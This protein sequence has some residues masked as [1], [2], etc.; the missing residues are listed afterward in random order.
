MESILLIRGISL[1]FPDERGRPE[2]RGEAIDLAVL[3]VNKGFMCVLPY[4]VATFA[5]G[6]CIAV[7]AQ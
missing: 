2:S 4:P 3:I 6:N 5:G 7:L 1:G